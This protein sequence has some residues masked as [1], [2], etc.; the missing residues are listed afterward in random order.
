V[1]KL[2]LALW[3]AGGAA[4]F[5]VLALCVATLYAVLRAPSRA[6]VARWPV[7]WIVALVAAAAAPWLVVVFAPIRIEA[8]IE[9]LGPLIAWLLAALLAFGVLIL[10]P[11]AALAATVVWSLGRRRG[12]PAPTG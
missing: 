3:L 9:G 1:P 10:L 12:G 7:R 5:V 11:I 8:K 2:P 6:L 4:A